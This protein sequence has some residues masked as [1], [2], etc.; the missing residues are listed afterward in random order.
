MEEKMNVLYAKEAEYINL[1]AK[2]N[3]LR[4]ERLEKEKVL[5]RFKANEGMEIAE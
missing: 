3:G 2:A 1:S 4:K 5:S